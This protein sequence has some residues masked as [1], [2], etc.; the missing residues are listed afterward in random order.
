MSWEEQEVSPWVKLYTNKSATLL[1]DAILSSIVCSF[2]HTVSSTYPLHTI[3]TGSIP[4]TAALTMSNALPIVLLYSDFKWLYPCE[5]S[6]VNV[7]WPLNCVMTRPSLSR[8]LL[9]PES[10][11]LSLFTHVPIEFR[12]S[13]FHNI[14]F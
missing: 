11:L 7:K 8:N 9:T 6:D 2:V 4:D 3:L 12:L 10:K 1:C 14:A 5:Q 13:F